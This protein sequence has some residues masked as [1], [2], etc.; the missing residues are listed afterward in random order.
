MMVAGTEE[1]GPAFG[2]MYEADRMPMIRMR[3]PV[4]TPTPLD[5]AVVRPP[6]DADAREDPN[7]DPCIEDTGVKPV[8][9]AARV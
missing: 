8:S 6:V 1:L 4:Q 5:V 7:K 3:V 9:G 2:M